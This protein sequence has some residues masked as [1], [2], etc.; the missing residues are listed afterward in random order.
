[1]TDHRD[2]QDHLILSVLKGSDSGMTRREIAMLL[3]IPKTFHVS[4][5][6]KSLAERDL[7][8]VKRGVD[9]RRR[10]VF[11]YY[12]NDQQESK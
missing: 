7:V 9:G 11:I 12:F 1:M 5:I 4:K 2:A 3:R 10:N 6:C 8:I